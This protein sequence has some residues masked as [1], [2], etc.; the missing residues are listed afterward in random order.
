M[1]SSFF[2]PLAIARA[3]VCL[4]SAEGPARHDQIQPGGG[5]KRPS[6]HGPATDYQRLMGDPGNAGFA[7]Q[8]L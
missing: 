4:E 8:A 5:P 1:I 6:V 2:L 7:R 3:R